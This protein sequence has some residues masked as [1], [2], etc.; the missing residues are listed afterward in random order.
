MSDDDTHECPGCGA[1]VADGEGNFHGTCDDCAAR[2]R[3]A[4]RRMSR[5][6]YQNP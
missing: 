4:T 1:T 3:E 2:H 5:M 6:P